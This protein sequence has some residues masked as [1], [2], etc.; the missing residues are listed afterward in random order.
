MTP[1][2]ALLLR[3]RV[4]AADPVAGG[5]GGGGAV[6]VDLAAAAAAAAAAAS[7]SEGGGV[8]DDDVKLG[9]DADDTVSGRLVV[10]RIEVH[11]A[12]MFHNS[13]RILTL[14][15]RKIKI[16]AHDTSTKRKK[17]GRITFGQT[18]SI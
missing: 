12:G 4:G 13:P 10:E 3:L 2:V 11:R 15:M 18:R 1:F 6:D 5:G 16:A 7:G 17:V 9:T 8:D 14:S